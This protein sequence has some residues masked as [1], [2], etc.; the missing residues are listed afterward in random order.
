[1]VCYGMAWSGIGESNQ[2]AL[3]HILGSH[4]EV[5]TQLELAS[6]HDNVSFQRFFASLLTQHA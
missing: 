3:G 1:M 2:T 4:S 6:P 5:Q